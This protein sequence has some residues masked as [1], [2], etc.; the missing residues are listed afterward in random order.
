[1]RSVREITSPNTIQPR[2]YSRGGGIGDRPHNFGG[3]RTT[4]RMSRTST[5]TM[6]AG[7]RTG[8]GSTTTGT[9][10]T[11]CS[12]AN[13]FN[14]P[15]LWAGASPVRRSVPSNGVYFSK[16][17]RFFIQPPSIMP[18]DESFWE[19]RVNFPVS[20]PFAS[21]RIVTK[22]FRLSNLRFSCSRKLNLSSRFVYCAVKASSKI[23]TNNSS[24]FLP[25]VY[26]VRR[27]R[28]VKK[29]CHNK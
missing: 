3:T 13:L 17:L 29:L 27:G 12:A 14:A 18:T 15:V 24:I 5:G 23:F 6:I 26:R 9:A 21:Q 19:S 11:G 22:N 28:C 20:I 8:T 2:E 4:V 1:M 25:S 7:T 16:D 10:T